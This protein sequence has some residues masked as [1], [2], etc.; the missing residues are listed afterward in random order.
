MSEHTPGPWFVA[1]KKFTGGAIVVSHGDPDGGGDS[2]AD[3]SPCGPWV[4]KEVAEANAHLIAAA[5]DM[6]KTLLLI[7]NGLKNRAIKDATLI[8]FGEES[9][10]ME[11]LS[12]IVAATLAKARPQ[13]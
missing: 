6:L 9:T 13:S 7:A 2:I 5:P 3:V 1:D 10:E 4:S 11:S 8:R 12:E